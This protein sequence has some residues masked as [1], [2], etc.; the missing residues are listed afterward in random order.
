MNAHSHTH[1]VS[2]GGQHKHRLY[3]ALALTAVYLI[4][5]VVG[6]LLTGSLALLADAGHMFTDVFGLVMAI[7]AITLG[8]RPP[9]DRK[10]YGY[11]RAEILAAMLNAILLALVSIYIF[12]EAYRRLRNP[13]EIVGGWMMAVA[14]VGLAVNLG[15]MVILRKGAGESLNL[16]GAYLE[17]LG[18][19]LGSLG[20]IIAAVIIVFT[21]WKPA[22]PIIG[23]GIGCFILPR[24]FRLMRQSVNILMEGTPQD[25]DL[26]EVRRALEAIPDVRRVHDLHAWTITSGMNALSAHLVLDKTEANGGVLTEAQRVL[27]ERF[28]IDHSTLQTE[29]PSFDH[30]GR[31]HE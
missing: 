5:E 30:L 14:G 18:D 10:T 9:S 28:E 26:D 27:H 13:P 29:P 4:A 23:I 11:Y 1:G 2:A 12:Y 31:T 16:Q 7:V 20:V 21:G 3:S 6:G 17:V 15:S 25:L 24:A 8:E 22:D 19:V